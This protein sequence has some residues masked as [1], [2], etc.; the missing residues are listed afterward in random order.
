VVSLT[1]GCGRENGKCS[2]LPARFLDAVQEQA[3]YM[4]KATPNTE[5]EQTLIVSRRQLLASAALIT[6][7]GTVPGFEQAE[8]ANSAKVVNVGEAPQQSEVPA[9]NVSAVTARRLAEIAERNRMRAEAA[10][11]LLSITKE[12]RRMK[13]EA[14]ATDF[15]E[16]AAVHRAAVCDEVLKQVREVSRKPNWRPTSFMQG[17]AFHSR[18]D[19][20]LHERFMAIP[21]RAMLFMFCGRSPAEHQIDGT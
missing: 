7:T 19:K 13:E 8:A 15:R 1:W 12:L 16:F 6:T 17:L 9:L 5:F 14:D 3:G 18:V 10:L 4:A 11:P 21:D 2:G 20:I